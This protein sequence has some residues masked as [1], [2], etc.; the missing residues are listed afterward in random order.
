VKKIALIFGIA[1]LTSSIVFG[2][3]INL[4][5]VRVLALANSR[6]LAKYKLAIQG[7]VLDE[8]SRIYSNLPSLSL[9]ASASMS[10][11]SAESAAPIENPFDT[12]SAGASVS[13]SQRI[14][15]GGK[16]IIQKAINELSTESAR[17]D[18]LA[19]YYNVLDSAD[20]AYYAV[21]E[22]LATLEAEESSL[23]NANT[24][25]SIAEVRQ[26]GGIINRGDY[27]KALAEKEGRE[28]TRNQARRN[29]VLS[30]AKLKSLTGLSELPDIEQMDFSGLE[31]L[32]LRLGAISDDEADSLCN[33]FWKLLAEA[34]PSLAKASLAN[35][36]AEKNLD[37]AKTAY[38]PTLGA[39]FSTGLNYTQNSG[40]ERSGGR[41]SLSASIPIDFW[42]LSNNVEKSRLSRDSAAL[43]YLSAEIQL[44]TELQTALL[45]LFSYAGSFLSSRRSLEYAEQHF[46]Y[47][48]ERY[49][50]SQSSVSEYGDAATLLINSRNSHIKASYGFL[51][52]LSKLRSMAAID[53]EKRLVQLL[54][55]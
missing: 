32:I 34:N 51:Q 38:S 18:A 10:L 6:S 22:A 1:V 16:T 29:L 43:D 48:S 53:D 14:F 30:V 37:M 31:D 47:V 35:R 28:N 13:V 3:T 46:E 40:L 17:K 41:V 19:E 12:F 50:L 20:N 45:N 42:V 9:G 11:W 55:L 27:L 44:E 54:L 24:S 49:R 52:S 2:E 5:Q 25:L 39:S 26:A 15:E 33:Q 23:A 21:L 36:R 8:R 4:E 7:A